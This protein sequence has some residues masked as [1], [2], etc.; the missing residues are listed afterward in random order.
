MGIEL[1]VRRRGA[2]KREN[3]YGK[4]IEIRGAVLGDRGHSGGAGDAHQ[5]HPQ[6]AGGAVL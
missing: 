5:A 3:A 4:F 1:A 2:G 6:Q